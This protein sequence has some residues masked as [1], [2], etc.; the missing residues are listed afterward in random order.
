M[1]LLQSSILLDLIDCSSDKIAL[2][3]ELQSIKYKDLGSQINRRSAD[4]QNIEVLGLAMNNSVEWIL[5]DLA[6]LQS[7]TVC[8]PLPSFFTAEQT[9]HA[10][11]S[12]GISHIKDNDSLYATGI[13]A[14]Q[15]I[16][17]D[18]VKITYT[19]GTTGSPK[20]V[21]LSEQGMIDVANSL[22]TSLADDFSGRH[23]C[24][25]PFAVL[26]EN[27]A[28]VYAALIANCTIHITDLNNYGHDYSK[29]YQTLK[30]VGAT[31]VIVVPEILCSLIQQVKVY[32]PLP[33]LAFIAV[34]GSKINSEL[35]THAKKSGLPVFEGYG[36][37]ECSSVV[38]LNTSKHC[39]L[40]SVG[41]I[42]PHISAKIVKGE[43]VITNPTFLG[44][45]GESPPNEFYTGDLAKLDS[46]GYLSII[47]RAKNVLITSY[48]R[49][50][51]PEWVESL[52]LL[53]PDIHQALVFGDGKPSLSAIIVPFSKNININ[54]ILTNVNK[55]LPKYAHI[56]KAHLVEPFTIDKNQLTGTG[57][58]RRDIILSHYNF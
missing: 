19:S 46:D 29:L 22:A 3:D 17:N 12:A 56:K 20:G 49:N 55:G 27:I 31:S 34:G 42:L 10:I 43:L 39:K 40:G 58:P 2:H 53:S 21:C 36:L 35:L 9:N 16:P 51:S 54:E 44:Y 13:K 30:K 33:L 41:K 25:L 18:T 4:L 57:R 1:P 47:G 50:I 32:G 7:K 8:V 37:S 14:R 28:G 26:L 15:S 6:A 24:C 38:A 48:G 45:L 52:L 23:L 5:W 11:A